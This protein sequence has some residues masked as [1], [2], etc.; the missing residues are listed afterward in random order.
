MWN[1]NG[2]T[3]APVRQYES[4]LIIKKLKESEKWHVKVYS[5]A[6]LSLCFGT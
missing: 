1:E 5:F 3:P 2:S 6:A 4:Q